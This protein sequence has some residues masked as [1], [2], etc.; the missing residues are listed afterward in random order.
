METKLE[1]ILN[2]VEGR[3]KLFGNIICPS[4]GGFKKFFKS[5]VFG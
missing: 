2:Y 4:D 1:K 3:G 5:K